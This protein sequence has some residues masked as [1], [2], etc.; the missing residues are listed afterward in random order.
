MYSASG[1]CGRLW[2][3]SSFESGLHPGFSP[4]LL[5]K[6]PVVENPQIQASLPKQT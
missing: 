2:T 1:K 4:L 5:F 6:H 3:P